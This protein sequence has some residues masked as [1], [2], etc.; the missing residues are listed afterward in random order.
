MWSGVAAKTTASLPRRE[1]PKV[2]YVVLHH[3]HPARF[4][5]TRHVAESLDLCVLGG[6]VR[7]GVAQDVDEPEAARHGGGRKVAYHDVDV[8][9]SLPAEFFGH[10]HREARYLAPGRRAGPMGRPP[11]RSRCRIRVLG[12]ARPSLPGSRRP[13]QRRQVRKVPARAWRTDGRSSHRSG[14]RP[15]PESLAWYTSRWQSSCSLFPELETSRSQ[16]VGRRLRRL[17]TR[18]N[19]PAGPASSRLIGCCD[20]VAPVIPGLLQ[21]G[22]AAGGVARSVLARSRGLVGVRSRV[23]VWLRRRYR[24]VT[25]P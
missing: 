9:S 23:Q 18:N 6:E 15:R 16:T 8:A 2:G 12:P 10:R 7:D 11:G 3:E 5:M 22:P 17:D 20:Y 25:G 4:E 21:S 13:A 24:P 1:S 14:S 19:C